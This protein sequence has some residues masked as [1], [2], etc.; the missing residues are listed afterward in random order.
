MKNCKLPTCLPWM[1]ICIPEKGI[2]AVV[3]KQNISLAFATGRL[4]AHIGHV[5]S[6]QLVSWLDT[7]WGLSERSLNNHL[8]KGGHWH[9][10]R[11]IVRTLVITVAPMCIPLLG[12]VVGS[13][14]EVWIF[15]VYYGWMFLTFSTVHFDHSFLYYLSNQ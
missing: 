12:W 9:K 13:A 7:S 1:A 8:V 5:C 3:G 15:S 10:C 2:L 14:A 4:K 6:T 11:L